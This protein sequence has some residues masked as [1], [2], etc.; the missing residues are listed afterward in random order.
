MAEFIELKSFS[1]IINEACIKKEITDE[2]LS[3]VFHIPNERYF[4]AHKNRNYFARHWLKN[5]RFLKAFCKLLDINLEYIVKLSKNNLLLFGRK[6]KKEEYL[7]LHDDILNSI[8][9]EEK[10]K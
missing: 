7:K 3:N 1:K 6:Y 9:V 5:T 2:E 4:T 8:N 10:E